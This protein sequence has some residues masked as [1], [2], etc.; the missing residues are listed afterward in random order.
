MKVLGI[1]DLVKG[2]AAQAADQRKSDRQTDFDL[3][4]HV[5]LARRVL[6]KPMLGLFN[7]EKLIPLRYCP[8]QIELELV[9]SQADAV[10]L[11][12]AEAFSNGANWD[13]SDI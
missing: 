6:F 3:S 9:N 2:A 8:I 11:G 7:Q 13:M 10:S 5:G 12:V 1:L 4:G